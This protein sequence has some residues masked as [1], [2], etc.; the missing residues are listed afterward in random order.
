[1]TPLRI[2]V[3]GGGHLGSIHARLLQQVP[4]AELAA[5]VEPNT[6]RAAELQDS[7]GCEVITDVA[8]FLGQP[9][10]DAVVLAAPTTLHREL[11]TQ[12][13]HQGVHCLIEKPLAASVPECE[14]LVE[15]AAESGTTLQVG[16][17]ERFNPAWTTMCT[18]I[19][20]PRL[21][22][23]VREAPLTFRSL[24]AGVVLDLMIHDIDLVLSLVK[25]PVATV[26]ASG[27]AWTGPSEDMAQAR[28]TFVNGAVATLTASRISTQPKRQMRIFGRDWYSEIDFA[29]RVCHIVD[30]PSQGDWQ[31]RVFVAEER[32]RLMDSLFDTI[33][34]RTDL[35]VPDG[36]PILDELCDF[37]TSIRSSSRPIVPGDD[38]LAAVAIA[39]QVQQRIARRPDLTSSFR[40]Q[41]RKA[42]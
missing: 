29:N 11:G 31:T 3:V 30:G 39:N 2:A 35:E 34:P 4:D 38:G 42:G 1:M 13:L 33:T 37:V 16:H 9:N 8:R 21:I 10:V 7:S 22:Q 32:Q 17:V 18:A 15:A 24:D 23:A 27:F 36:N 41:R 28:I 12:L 14:E 26:Q 5:I 40:G 19:G 25:S 20:E 6:D